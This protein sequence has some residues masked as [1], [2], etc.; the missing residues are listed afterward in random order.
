MIRK[1]AI[2]LF[3]W[4]VFL[5]IVYVGT[6]ASYWLI[7]YL[8]SSGAVKS[9]NIALACG[10]GCTGVFACIGMGVALKLDKR[11]NL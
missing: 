6:Q 3:H 11:F 10:M 1:I 5:V 7:W 8:Q 9:L 4:A 2:T